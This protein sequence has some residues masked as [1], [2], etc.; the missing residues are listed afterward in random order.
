MTYKEIK[1]RLSKCELTLQNIKDGSYSNLSADKAK[2]QIQ[3]LNTLKES[4]EKQLKEASTGDNVIITTKRGET[5]VATGVNDKAA[6]QLKR[7]P[8]IDS[9]E[10]T[11]GTEIKEGGFDQ[12][13]TA[14][15]AANVGKAVVLALN[16]MGESI[17][18]AR[19]VNIKPDNFNVRVVFKNDNEEVYEFFINEDD[20]LIL[21]NPSY[22]RDLA[23]VGAKP[24]GEAVV[25]VDV[26][27]DAFGKELKN[28]MSETMT[29]Q[30]FRDAKEK[31]RLEKHPEKDTIKKI[32]AL[33][34]RERRLKNTK[35]EVEEGEYAA[36]KYNVNVFGYQTKHYKICPGA[37]SFMEKVVAGEHGKVDKEETI[38]L[39]K[40]HDLL[41]LYEIR[42]LKDSA[43]FVV[44]T[45]KDQVNSMDLPV[46]EVD[47]LDSH[48][49]K[50]KDAAKGVNEGEGDD[51]HYIK[52]PRT[53]YKKAQKVI[54]DVLANDV[55]GGHKHDIVDNLWDLKKE[56]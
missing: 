33:I 39:A 6:S 22:D 10:K 47:Y 50:I 5:K 24:S 31:D 29:D 23:D 48:I 41:F 32:Q 8:N 44:K 51:H 7:D 1:D 42:A 27:K 46:D 43:E 38:R 54:D 53:Q 13:E 25:N 35:E 19:V 14:A 34:A 12:N 9:I 2:I 52:V 37:K 3:K 17:S 40:L 28:I 20:R 30:E 18:T 15:I 21:K 55:Y 49:E 4:L 45:I 11:D 56:L 16:S 26:V 36:D